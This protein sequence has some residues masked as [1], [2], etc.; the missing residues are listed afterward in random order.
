MKRPAAESVIRKVKRRNV[1]SRKEQSKK[2]KDYFEFLRIWDIAG[3]LVGLDR[4]SIASG[5][6]S[7]NS[8]ADFEQQKKEYRMKDT[9]RRRMF[10]E[11]TNI[12]HKSS[13]QKK[14]KQRAKDLSLSAAKKKSGEEDENEVFQRFFLSLLLSETL[15]ASSFLYLS[16]SSAN[17]AW[18]AIV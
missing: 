2:K 14:N 1:N 7:I 13:A 8:R 15:K 3:R 5:I 17:A 9:R 12:T 4:I 16:Y 6:V 11:L 18:P 10:C